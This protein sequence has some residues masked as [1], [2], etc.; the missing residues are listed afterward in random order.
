MISALNGAIVSLTHED[1]KMI[2]E[3]DRF[4]QAAALL[5]TVVRKSYVPGA[6]SLSEAVHT[7]R[8]NSLSA[9][10]RT[11]VKSCFDPTESNGN[12]NKVPLEVPDDQQKRQ[13]SLIKAAFSLLAVLSAINLLHCRSSVKSENPSRQPCEYYSSEI[14]VH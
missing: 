11:E 3:S 6:L 7:L 12:A 10:S 9:D 13:T 5:R 2:L 8:L 1:G 4:G 14:S